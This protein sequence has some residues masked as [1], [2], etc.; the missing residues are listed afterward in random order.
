MSNGFTSVSF[1]LLAPAEGAKKI[2][3]ILLLLSF[4]TFYFEICSIKN[5]EF[6]KKFE[7]ETRNIIYVIGVTYYKYASLLS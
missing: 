7:V 4:N 1:P 6:E 2:Y 3:R 5:L